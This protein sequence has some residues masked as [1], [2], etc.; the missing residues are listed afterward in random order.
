MLL[1]HTAFYLLARGLPGLINFLALSVYTRL[2]APG[3]YG[4]Y[5]LALATVSLTYTVIFQWINSGLLR[6]LPRHA[7]REEQLQSTI[8]GVYSFLVAA[9]ALIGAVIYAVAVDQPWRGLVPVA[10]CLLWVQAWLELNL[11]ILSSRFK[12]IRYGAL[13]TTRATLALVMGSF[14][15]WLGWS[16]SGPLWGMVIGGL[17]AASWF[18]RS[19]WRGVRLGKPDSAL[20]RELLAYGLPLSIT[21]IFAFIISTSDRYLIAW[22]MDEKAT[23]LY[24]A[25]Y[26]LAQFSL[27]MLMMIV[28]LAAYPIVVRALEREGEAAARRNLERQGLLLLTIAAPATVGFALLAGNI[29]GVLLGAE[30]RATAEIIL[31]WIAL[32]AFVGGLKAFYFDLAFQ[33]GQ[34]TTGQVW[35]VMSA[36]LV[37]VVL[38]LIWIPHYGLLGAAWATLVAYIAALALSV[39]LGKAYFNLPLVPRNSG[40][41]LA[42]TGFMGAALFPLREFH[43]VLPLLG[44]ILLGL[45]VYGSAL[46]LFDIGGARA[47]ALHFWRSRIR[48]G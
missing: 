35:V 17:V 22:L 36:G 19:E 8:L 4:R 39:V 32:A 15:I 14:L 27:G 7:G 46:I 25:G 10:I 2:L 24:S 20:V 1:Q 30:Y 41:V 5:A 47:H 29:S 40:K 6:F 16:A 13:S 3:E 45:L 26:D 28:N 18:G 31:P 37:N 21:F 38:N 48:A 43:G 34:R 11:Q 42:A 44:Q 9:S 12:P 23:G 33:L